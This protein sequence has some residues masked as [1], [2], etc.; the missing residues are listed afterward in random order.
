MSELGWAA[1]AGSWDIGRPFASILATARARR[2]S[3]YSSFAFAYRSFGVI[4]YLLLHLLS[5]RNRSYPFRPLVFIARNGHGP[6][7]LPTARTNYKLNSLLARTRQQTE[8]KT[9]ARTNGRTNLRNAPGMEGSA[10]MRA[11]LTHALSD[12]DDP[13]RPTKKIGWFDWMD[14]DIEEHAAS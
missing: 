6:L 12:I 7:P 14:M 3:L 9:N 11:E 5:S 1:G 8:L 10:K 4:P 2:R 13:D